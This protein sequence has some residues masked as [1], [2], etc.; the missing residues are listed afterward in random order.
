MGEIITETKAME[1]VNEFLNEMN[2]P[3]ARL[4]GITVTCY[5]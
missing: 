4:R 2:D 3:A 5:K 1:I